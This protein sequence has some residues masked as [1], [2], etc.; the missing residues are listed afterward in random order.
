M[1]LDTFKHLIEQ[2]E[3]ETLDF[4]A[5][6]HRLDNDHFKSKFIKD[7]LAMAN[8]IRNT[9]AYI[10]VGV[11][12][13]PDGRHHRVGV[14]IHPDDAD[15]QEI[16]KKAQ[17][18]PAL[19]FIYQDI[20][21]DGLSFGFIEIPLQT[22]GPFMAG[23]R[24]ELVEQQ[25]L[26]LR[27]GTQNDDGR[28]EEYRK[29]YNWFSRLAKNQE[30]LADVPAP[31]QDSNGNI[32]WDKFAQEC[33]HF[34]S[35]RLYA[36]LV[37]PGPAN[38]DWRFFGR[39]PIS[40]VLDFDPDTEAEGAYAHAQENIRNQ[41]S[42][43]LI[44]LGNEYALRP[45]R[46]CY[47]YSAR[48]LQGRAETLVGDDD[49]RGWNRKYGSAL[50]QLLADFARSG[51][52][53]PVTVVCLWHAPEYVREVCTAIDRAFGNTV[54][55]VFATQE[56]ERLSELARQFGGKTVAVGISDM[57]RGIERNIRSV[58]GSEQPAAVLPTAGGNTHT[59]SPTNLHWLAE[60]MIVV[61]SQ[62]ARESDEGRQP[63][64][65]FLRGATADWADLDLHFDA[66]RDKTKAIEDLVERELKSRTT[67]RLNLYH[68]PGA[69]GTTV[70]RRV[71]WNLHL[72]YPTVVLQR[73]VP[74]QTVGRF[75]EIFKWTSQPIL[76]VVE[77]ADTKHDQIERLYSELRTENIPVVFLTIVRRFDT[78]THSERIVF[79]GQNLN[80]DESYRFA[81]A[82]RRVADDKSNA[83]TGVLAKQDP[84]ERTPFHFALA[85]FGKEY[86]GLTR[87]VET[88]LEVATPAQRKILAFLALAYYYG[89][90]P[91]ITQLFA[92]HLSHPENRPL[93]LTSLLGEPQLELLVEEDAERWR[94]AHQ[95]IAEQILEIIL[96]GTAE[97]RGQWKRSLSSWAIEFIGICGESSALPNDDVVDLLGRIFILRNEHELLGTESS[98]NAKFAKL[99]EHVQELEGRKSILKELVAV[100]PEEA[101]FW[102]HLGRFYSLDAND[103]IE[104]IAAVDRAISLSPDDPVLYHMKGMCYRSLAIEVMR[105]AE[106]G[107]VA[108][109][110]LPELERVVREATVAFAIAR[111]LD[112][113]S[114]HGYVSAIQLLLKVIE[115]GYGRSGKTSRSEFLTSATAGWY[116]KL[117]DEVENLMDGVKG[118]REG[119]RASNYVIACQAELD[120]TIDN[121][122]RAIEGWTN[123]LQKEVF[124]PP[125]RR[126]IVRAYLGRQ[127]GRNWSKLSPKEIENVIDLM[128]EN[129]RE[130]PTNEH[131]IRLWLQAIRNSPRQDIDV[132][133]ERLA[134]W[135]ATG[136]GPDAFFYLYVLHALKAIDGSTLALAVSDDLIQQSQVRSRSLRNRTR[137]Y[138]WFGKGQGL[139]RLRHYT[140]LGEWDDEANFYSN[141]EPLARLE[142]RVATISRP[143]AGVIELSY[144]LKAF[145]VP[146][147]AGVTKGKDENQKVSFYLGFSYDGL[148]AWSV[149]PG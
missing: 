59:I 30:P 13:L 38:P 15:L 134:N 71:A 137:S 29:I 103:Q 58:D 67:A 41:R 125:I 22:D 87:Y 116:R 109:K 107:E 65:D 46:A 119:D 86:M 35:G 28:P 111:D 105:Q 42:L 40:L 52:G 48:G 138:E 131:N 54:D 108:E 63:G 118:G 141:T 142:G 120:R 24:I 62:I 34:G 139:R 21:L 36:A 115:F 9:P 43:H 99:I 127:K 126:Q 89:H 128:Q 79:L 130:E 31:S 5:E 96:S 56:A 64:A 75:R 110:T 47:W 123:L 17:V 146:A 124:A 57:L 90:K 6:P 39:L 1:D 72:R 94:P 92:R 101:H 149:Q 74:G 18:Q 20:W 25:R 16:L 27:R 121:Y 140:E 76:A 93:R 78:G 33:H 44:T 100:F 136:G 68:W 132:A 73:A 147:R 95:L 49:W 135:K 37:G 112:R 145:F 144:G 84:R 66:D 106:N 83:L 117:L 81:A 19:K 8:T 70:G 7:I 23:R 114:E 12:L 97:D 2:P 80:L 11:K 50:Q 45:E 129:L 51:G 61:H 104:A 122:S 88:R 133:I 32:H 82:Y 14:S 10:V 85:A 69:G 53:R 26:Y 60:D 77:G 113:A 4:K 3:S 91:V 148:R 98:A 143:E 55:F 102:G